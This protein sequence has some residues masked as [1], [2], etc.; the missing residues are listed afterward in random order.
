MSQLA[1]ALR[2]PDHRAR[3]LALKTALDADD[4]GAVDAIAAAM[5][6]DPHPKVRNAMA[7]IVGKLGT[8]T[9]APALVRLLRDPDAGVRLRA[10]E[11]IVALKDSGSYPALVATLV[12]ET[13]AKVRDFC[14]QQ[15][16]RLGGD[17]LMQLFQH[18]LSSEAV[19]MKEAAI[20]A[21]A[22]F[23]SPKV[24]PVLKGVH[25]RESGSTKELAFRSLERLA[26]MGN[27]L[28][29]RAVEEL[30]TPRL[31]VDFAN[32]DEDTGDGPTFEDTYTGGKLPVI[33]IA[34]PL[35]EGE[36]PEDDAPPVAPP[37]SDTPVERAVEALDGPPSGPVPKLGLSGEVSVPQIPAVAL[38][39][40]G[41]TRRPAGPGKADASSDDVS[42]PPL[43]AAPPPPVEAAPPAPAAGSGAGKRPR[44]VLNMDAARAAAP[45]APRPLADLQG[46][47][48]GNRPGDDT[49]RACPHCGADISA[50]AR[51]CRHCN[52]LVDG[53]MPSFVGGGAQIPFDL[54]FVAVL[55]WLLGSWEAY[56]QFTTG[57]A[58]DPAL[59]A[60]M[61]VMFV[62]EIAASA[63]TFF[64]YAWGWYMWW[65]LTF[66]LFVVGAS[67]G[68]AIGAGRSFACLIS[69]SRT[70]TRDFCV[71]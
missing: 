55:T 62:A 27:E 71:R 30:G 9:H 37:A 18:M 8:K 66:F 28:A 19:W 41:R 12:S 4:R 49:M 13:D 25:A 36:E 2:S 1:E 44:P 16:M 61:G 35:E 3:L 65:L 11:S 56:H 52:E 64:G 17:K 58:L 53:P 33:K 29:A 20:L 14:A 43:P 45:V 48:G 63:G 15:L 54:A 69:L 10:V 26:S 57:M 47:P 23:N 5:P 7:L 70:P 59:G 34:S 21:L 50:G 32:L 42:A 39:G 31:D 24:V 60:V 40:S 67:H 22:L 51:R 68:D 46:A 6:T 38:A